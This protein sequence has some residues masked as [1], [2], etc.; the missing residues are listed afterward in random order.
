[1]YGLYWEDILLSDIQYCEI[2]T[3]R[4]A[5]LVQGFLQTIEALPTHSLPKQIAEV[6]RD[7]DPWLLI[8]F[9]KDVLSWMQQVTSKPCNSHF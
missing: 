7:F 6:A 3:G 5:V 1:M 9:G 8:G 4:V 2:T